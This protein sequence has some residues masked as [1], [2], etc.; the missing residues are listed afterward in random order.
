[1]RKVLIIARYEYLV[2]VRRAGFI[3]MTALFPLIG[4][5]LVVAGGFFANNLVGS[6]VESAEREV[7]KQI[8]LVDYDGRFVPVLPEYE[9]RFRAFDSEEAGRAVLEQGEISTLAVIKEGYLA[10]GQVLLIMPDESS[11][12][13]GV[14]RYSVT[15]EVEAMLRDT[16]LEQAIGD[17]ALRERVENP[18]DWDY[19]TLHEP[20]PQVVRPAAPDSAAAVATDDTEVSSFMLEG[21]GTVFNFVVPY[22]FSFLL[23][24]SVFASSGYL[25]RGV[26]EEKSSRVIEIILSSVSARELLTGKIIGLGALGLTQD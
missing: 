21:A 5:I 14:S 26:S 16:L 23:F 2:N 1:M 8:G 9:E 19:T 25:M 4:L 6:M 7:E 22:F 20:Q 11:G 24:L 10:T 17:S 18:A 12:L 15:S 3:F 13:A